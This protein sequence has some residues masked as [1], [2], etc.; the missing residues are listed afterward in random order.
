M[1]C[2]ATHAQSP[3]RRF[4]EVPFDIL[5]VED[6]PADRELAITSI[7]RY[8][9]SNKI[10]LCN[11][12]E[13]ASRFILKQGE[14]AERSTVGLVLLDLNLP[15]LSGFDVLVL[16]RANPETQNVPVIVLTSSDDMPDIEEARKLG[17]DHYMVKPID[18]AKVVQ[19][20]KTLG[21]RWAL[22]PKSSDAT[23]SPMPGS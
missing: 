3:K 10:T 11:D 2:S 14:Y 22:L 4:V 18:F 12:G 7:Q 19:V 5:L 13:Q 8:R 15:T 17:A 9:L 1:F 6:N 16:I 21:F 20:A 23:R